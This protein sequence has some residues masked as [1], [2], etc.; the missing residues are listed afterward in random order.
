MIFDHN[1]ILN[2]Y[3]F[4]KLKLMRMIK[5]NHLINILTNNKYSLSNRVLLYM[6][7]D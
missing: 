6:I 3:L 5:F 2:H 4:K 1:I 7:L